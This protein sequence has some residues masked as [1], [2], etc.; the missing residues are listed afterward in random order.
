MR[1]VL[2]SKRFR[3]LWDDPL[4]PSATGLRDQP[5]KLVAVNAAIELQGRPVHLCKPDSYLM[6]N[7]NP[8][9]ETRFGVNG[10]TGRAKQKG[11]RDRLST[12]FLEALT[13]TFEE[14][15]K[16]AV[17]KVRDQDPSTYVRVF[18]G[19]LSKEVEVSTPEAALTDEQLEMVYAALLAELE[20]KGQKQP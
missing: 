15:G 11:A 19:L 16:E 20:A 4:K 12:A 7:P 14:G 6:A 18:A 13:E 2:L 5:A 8:S 17:R 1:A 9:P 10:H 3:P